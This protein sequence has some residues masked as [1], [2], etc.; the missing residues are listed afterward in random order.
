MR[1]W[2]RAND[3]QLVLAFDALESVPSAALEH[4]FLSTLDLAGDRGHEHLAWSRHSHEARCDADRHAPDLPFRQ[5]HL[6]GVDASPNGD[7]DRRKGRDKGE[8]APD[9][10]L[11]AVEQDEE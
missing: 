10:P 2:G 9:R 4:K 3:E 1:S 8:S 7:A 6:A 5:D 11:R